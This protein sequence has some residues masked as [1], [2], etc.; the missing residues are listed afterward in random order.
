MREKNQL[1]CVQCLQE[2]H[3]GHSTTSMRKLVPDL[4]EAHS[5][6]LLSESKLERLLEFVGN[7]FGSEF[8][9]GESTTIDNIIER[10]EELL[11]SL[12]REVESTGEEIN[13]MKSIFR[14]L[15]KTSG[16]QVIPKQASQPHPTA[17]LPTSKMSEFES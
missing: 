2:E 7:E 14:N 17:R 3:Q 1:S 16:S 11:V 12:K 13:K 15:N 8:L 5:G 4:L 10:V 9:S 6:R